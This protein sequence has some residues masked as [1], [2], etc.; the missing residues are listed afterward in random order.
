MLD[1]IA[2]YL[3]IGINR[4]FNV[5][6]MSATLWLGRRV[7]YMIYF[8]SGRRS[9]ITYSNLKAA[10]YAEKTPRELKRITK[11]VYLHLGETFA[12]LVAMTKVDKAYSE[13]YITVHNFDR[14]ERASKNTKGMIFT[15]AHLGNWELSCVAAVHKGYVLHLISRDQKMKRLNELFNMLRE[16]KGNFVIRKGMD[17]KNVFK[18]LHAGKSIGLLGD[19]NAGVNGQ[20][21]DFFGRPASLAQGPYRFAQKCGAWILPCFIWRVK[22][23]YHEVVAE[24]PME[25]KEGEDLLPY[26]KRYNELLEKHIRAH[27]N[28]WFWMHKRWKVTP[29]KKI[30]VLDDGKKGHLKQSLAVVKQIKKYRHDKGFSPENTPVDVIRINFRSEFRKTVFNAVTPLF[31]RYYQGRQELLKWALDE[32]SYDA[33]IKRYADV[34]VSC[35]SSLVGVNLALKTENYARNVTVLAPGPVARKKFTLVVVPAH[36]LKGKAPADNVAVTELAPNLIDPAELGGFLPQGRNAFPGPCVGLL[37]GGD[38]RYFSFGVESAR[39]VAVGIKAA[40]GRVNGH[41]YATTSRRTTPGADAALKELLNSDTRSAGFV[42]G[43]EDKDAHTVEKILAS[44]DVILVSGESISMV[45]E[46][47]SS[48]KPVLVFM[49]EKKTREYTKYERFVDRLAS[50]SYLKRVAVGDIAKEIENVLRQ[51]VKFTLPGDGQK[52]YEKTYK[53]F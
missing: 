5:I 31:C 43:R 39:S 25:I 30:L 17:I 16:S 19:Q 18:V 28:Q 13:K 50:R 36:D 48:G 23:P 1:L 49:P 4:L 41:F 53:L 26:M 12:E 29:L 46:A 52:I 33:A 40:C 20:L 51:K 3:V 21:V 37:A 44:S 8:L 45:S 34:V 47:V 10:F 6:P 24:E 14:I 35:G 27:P 2:S 38:N 9:R 32:K 22:G 42:V 11:Q 7:G 15:S